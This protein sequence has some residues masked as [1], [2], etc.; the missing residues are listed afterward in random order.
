MSIMRRADAL[1]GAPVLFDVSGGGNG[2]AESAGG[3][4]PDKFEFGLRGRPVFMGRIGGQRRHRKS[5]GHL[6]SAVEPERRP[7]DHR[8]KPRD[9]AV[10]PYTASVQLSE[11]ANADVENGRPSRSRRH[12]WPLASM[13]L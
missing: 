1:P 3:T 8:S 13:P 11:N 4:P 9:I 5:I 12:D 7:D 2:R 10:P 6:K